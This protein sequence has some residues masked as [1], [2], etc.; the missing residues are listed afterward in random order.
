MRRSLF[1]VVAVVLVLTQSFARLAQRA[2]NEPPRMSGSFPSDLFRE[3]QWRMIGPHRGGRTKAAAGIPDQP[4]VFFVGATNG[5]VWKTTD[6]G[7]IWTPIF[8]D[9][10]TGSIGAIA[11]A[12]SDP[13]VIYVG[14]GEGLQRPDLS[15][16][17]GIYKST[18]GGS[19]W[20][21]L[22]LRDGQQI[23]QIIVHPKDPNRLYV[24][25]LGHP[26]GPNEERGI[27]RSTDGAQTFQKVLYKDENTGGVDVAFDPVRSRHALRGAVGGASGTL[28][29]RG[30]D[31][32]RAAASSNRP[33][34][35][36]R[37]GRS[38][39]DCR[40]S[41]RAASGGSALPSRQAIRSAC[42][43]PSKPRSEGGL[44][45]SDDAGESWFRVT[46]DQRVV[47]RGSDFAEVKVHPK[48]PD[49][50]F[51][52]SIVA[53][54][55]TDG[56]KTFTAFRGAP[57]G[58]DYHRFWINP[59][60]PDIIL[61]AADQGVVITVNGG[62][63][64]SSWYNQPTAQMY[65]VTHRQ[66]VS[67]TACAA[68]SRRAARSAFRA[69]ATTGGLRFASGIRSASRNTGTSRPT[70]STP[71]SSTA[72][73]SAATTVAPDRCRTSR[74][75]RAGETFRAVRTAPVLFS[76]V[77]PHTLYFAQNVALEDDQRRP[78]LDADQSRSH[79]QDLGR[80]RQRRQIPRRRLVAADPARR[81]LH[82]LRRRTSTSTR[83][84]RAPTT[85]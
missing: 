56:G 32:A 39:R 79:A 48:N 1:F 34:A 69:A 20:T 53:W 85:A 15:T 76:P 12:P 6:Y 41:S 72:A 24:A 57:G 3:M 19:T 13:N 46:D 59:I 37:G 27:F 83:S 50:V 55:S 42:S 5:G 71:T 44:Y 61:I 67:R 54:K 40:R 81:H 4:N 21:H 63:T 18:D 60:N 14:T 74:R 29:E 10:P 31:R 16:G 64:W 51:T 77:D 30:L 45:R 35:A 22:G 38:R 7:R 26:Y 43:R 78:E 52:G 58:D 23:P 36:R 28:G 75:G 2:A 66:R 9:Q 17:N 65:H 73:K 25:V 70:R 8:D 62:E 82:R 80:P 11:I 84:G 68:A 33:T 47:S 49:I